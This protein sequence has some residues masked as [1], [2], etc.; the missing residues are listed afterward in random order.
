MGKSRNAKSGSKLTYKWSVNTGIL[1]FL[2]DEEDATGGAEAQ[3]TLDAFA[4]YDD[5]KSDCIF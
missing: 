2:S 4:N 3:E 1:K 5:E